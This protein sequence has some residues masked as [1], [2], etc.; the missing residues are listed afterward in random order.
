MPLRGVDEAFVQT[1][2]N[3]RFDISQSEARCMPRDL[4]DKLVA[5]IVK[6]HPIKKIAFDG[7]EDTEV[8]ESLS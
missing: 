2:E 6:K 5:G 1:L 3:I 4:N 8:S 7:P